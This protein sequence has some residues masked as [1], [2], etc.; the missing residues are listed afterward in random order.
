MA[1]VE[2]VCVPEEEPPMNRCRLTFSTLSLLLMSLAWRP[3]SCAEGIPA[4][5]QAL[6]VRT[7]VGAL[8]IEVEPDSVAAHSGLATGD[9]LGSVDGQSLRDLRTLDSYISALRESAIL[10]GAVTE[11]WH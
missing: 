8:V 10:R 3:A 11:V 5:D 7:F 6:N 9:V 4:F 1:R 2:F